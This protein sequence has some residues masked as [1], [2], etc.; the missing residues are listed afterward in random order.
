MT[1]QSVSISFDDRPYPFA[2]VVVFSPAKASER[3]PAFTYHV[4]GKLDKRVGIGSLVVVPFGKR[5][6]Y[7]VVV[8]FSDSSPVADTRPIESLVDPDPVLSPEHIALARW[9]RDEYLAS[10]YE[11]LE[12]MLPPGM[13]GHTDLKVALSGEGPEDTPL[14][15]YANTDAQLQLLTMLE[16]R[17]PLRG[18][19]LDAALRGVDW[20]AAS[21]QLA[22]RDV[23]SRE[24][25]LAPPR[26]QPK[27]VDTVQLVPDVDEEAAL[28]GLRSDYYPP[29]LKLL[30]AEKRPVPV[31]R[32]YE[33]TG[34]DSYHLGKL[35]ERGLIVFSSEEV[36]RDPLDD[37]VFVPTKPPP[38]TSDQQEVWESI[39]GAIQW[40]GEASASPFESSASQLGSDQADRSVRES[41][42][43]RESPGPG[44]QVF[45]LH[46][47]T[48]S[49]K[50]EIYLRAVAD[51]LKQGR[52][53]IILVPEIS[54]TAQT[55]AR[56]AGRFWERGDGG[57]SRD[58]QQPGSRVAVLH[59]A[60]TDGER[61]DTWRRARAGLVD[62]VVGPRSA[63]FAPLSPLG[64]IV[65]DEEHDDSYKQ[66]APRP[67]Y[68]A[69]DTALRLA[70]SSRAT[71][72][73]GSATPSLTSYH[74]AQQGEFDL[75]E[76]PRRIM[77]HARRLQELQARYQVPDIRYQAW[78][79][80]ETD[81]P[82]D[83]EPSGDQVPGAGRPPGPAA[84]T[85]TSAKRRHQR[86]PQARYLPLPPVQIVDLRAELRAGNR[87][88]FSR[89]L[90]QAMDKALGRG[91]QV[92]LFLNRRGS[93]TF[94]LCRDCGHVVRCPHCDVPLT[95]HSPRAR[96]ICHHCNYR[97]PQPQRCPQCGGRRIR[98]FGLG[99]ERVEKA[100]RSRWPDARLLRWDRDTARTHEA[101]TNILQRFAGGAAD[102]LVGTQMITKGLDLPLV[103]VVGVISADTA[104]N[105]PDFRSSERTFQLL[106]QVAGRAGRGLLGGRVVIQ[107]YHPDHYAI[108]AASKHDY[109]AFA[110]QELAFRREQ[111]YPPYIRLAKLIC[112]DTA[113]GR[114][115]ARAK[116]MSATLRDA[117]ARDALPATYLLGPAPP[118]FAR[119]RGRYRWQ[120]LLRH[121]DP[122]SFLGDIRI[123]DGWRVEV[124]PVS[125]L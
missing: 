102:V 62:V 52:K 83:E 17:G 103:T 35:E 116:E 1:E 4:P 111:G 108:V 45:L 38:L 79:D 120:I 22:Q 54:L 112:E 23:V 46:G 31:P 95:Y 49:G 29:I 56:F 89:T 15:S 72:I 104:L 44:P 97:E 11:C 50:T 3:Q 78:D 125:V 64:L 74:R 114:A 121:P 115:R 93:A 25:F 75:Q 47:V 118:F 98:Y 71:V 32:V 59:S 113:S 51:V 109:L 110:E 73:L 91:E 8:A 63:L 123:P 85:R 68:H 28:E 2:N 58:G 7:G 106:A 55:V 41:A 34:C 81:H 21:E 105:L 60:L 80:E 67:R 30:H 92:I 69:R 65:L 42:K 20:R 14:T 48:G 101:H 124:D 119:L 61:Y 24:S 53:A 57:R 9:M 88:I 122:P 43:V 94:V 13:V 99:T 107:T 77:G 16:R 12:L 66:E 6:L 76:M 37:D 39:K 27:R 87:S 82:E 96:L 86:H 19:Q 26:A 100:V 70:R 36:W 18:T 10:L 84:H 117:L 5:R 90:Q 40:F 33:E